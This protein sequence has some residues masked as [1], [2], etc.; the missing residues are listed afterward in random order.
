MSMSMPILYGPGFSYFLRSVRLLLKYKGM[1]HTVSNAPYENEIPYFGKEHAELHPFKKIPVLVDGS[2]V[3]PETLAIAWYIESKTGPSFLP[4]DAKQQAQI[5]SL[6]C[7]I[8]QYVHKAIIANIILEF[9]FPKGKE[10]SIRL[11]VINDNLPQAKDVLDWLVKQLDNRLYL[12]ADQFT[13]ADAYLIPMIDYLHQL[14]AP[15]NLSLV[16]ESLCQY[17]NHHREQDYS[18]GVLGRP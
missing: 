7:M 10:G 3:L 12:V 13:L 11:D 14:P 2:F 16:H 18:I 15:Y 9:R 5:F 17:I 6:A 1:E 8:S 4:G